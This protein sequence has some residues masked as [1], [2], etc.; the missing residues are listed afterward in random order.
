[1]PNLNQI[2][3]SIPEEIAHLGAEPKDAYGVDEFCARHGISRAFLYLLWRR[4]EGPAYMQLGGRR[5]ISKE[6]GAEWRRRM[7]R[8]PEAVA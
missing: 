7:E 6:A 1:M 8:Q 2:N 4:G 3:R 5:V